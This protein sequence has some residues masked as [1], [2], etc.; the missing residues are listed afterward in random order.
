MKKNVIVALHPKVHPNLKIITALEPMI[1]SASLG[2]RLSIAHCIEQETH[3]L[4]AAVCFFEF[5]NQKHAEV[6]LV[7]AL[8]R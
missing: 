2:E 6:E 5:I 1:I 8:P 7:I 4:P 3:G